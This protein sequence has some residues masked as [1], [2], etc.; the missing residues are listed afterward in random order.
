V[1]PGCAQYLGL[2]GGANIRTRESLVQC[3]AA[4]I[5]KLDCGIDTCCIK[6]TANDDCVIMR[7]SRVAVNLLCGSMIVFTSC[8]QTSRIR[9]SLAPTP[10]SFPLASDAVFLPVVMRSLLGRIRRT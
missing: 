1:L 7:R 6:L 2:R 3:R 10:S 4:A 9:V 8:S 5:G